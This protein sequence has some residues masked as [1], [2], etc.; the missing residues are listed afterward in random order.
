MSSS[1]YDTVL[2]LE[3]DPSRWLAAWI[4]GWY[5]FALLVVIFFPLSWTFYGEI[6]VLLLLAVILSAYYDVQHYLQQAHRSS[7]LRAVW[8]DTGEWEVMLADYRV[9]SVILSPNSFI[10]PWL[11]CLRFRHIESNQCYTL[12]LFVDALAAD[13]SRQL[14]VRLRLSPK[15]SQNH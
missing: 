14:R 6:R 12:L 9:Q 13:T 5:G 8:N 1:P 15:L 3:P 10:T 4:W 2:V 7:V 11:M